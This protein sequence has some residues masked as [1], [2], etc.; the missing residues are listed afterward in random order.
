M[1]PDFK[2]WI[3]EAKA[4]GLPEVIMKHGGLGLKRQGHRLTGPCPKCGGD[5]RFYVNPDKNLFNCNGCDCGKGK[6]GAVDFTEFL[7]GCD[8]LRAC[9]T[10]TGRP[11]PK[12][13]PNG[14]DKKG[15]ND[16]PV[17]V[18][19]YD[20][21]DEGGELHY[22]V[23]RVQYA[24]PDGNWILKGD[25]PKKVFW[26]RRPDSRPG[27]WI[28]NVEGCRV[29]PYRL[30][31]LLEALKTGHIIFHVEGER[32]VNLLHDIGLDA[33][34]NSGGSEKWT[35]EHSAFFPAGS[36]NI[37]L[38]DADAAGRK[39][40]NVVAASLKEVGAEVK[41]LELPGLPGKGDIVDWV[42]VGGT[43]EQLIELARDAK[44]WIFKNGHDREEL[45]APAFVLGA[46]GQILKGHPFNISL[47]IERLG[48]VL[49]RNE[50][51]IQIEITNLEGYGPELTDAG[52]I[53][54]RL[55]THETF[56]FLPSR[57]LFEQI[58]TD[59]AHR[60]RYHP[61][62]DFLAGLKW[63]GEPRIDNWLK[64]YAGAEDTDFNRAVGRIILIAGVRRVRQP[65]VKFDT[66][67]V[68]ESPQGRDKS[69]ALR[70]LATKGEWF[71][72]NLP[73]SADP[74]QVIEATGGVWIAEFAELDGITK[75]D[76]GHVKNF[77]SKQDDR[78]RAAYGRRSERVPRQ[79]ICCGTTNDAQYLFD[80][81][82][83]RF[84]PV[85]ITQFNF[86]ALKRVIDQLWAE[87]AHYEAE[88]ESIVLQ[89][90]LWEA[91]R[92]VQ[93]ARETDNPIRDL[94]A[95]RLGGAPGWVSSET[96]WS[97]I[98]NIPIDRRQ[99]LSAPVGRAMKSLGFKRVQ[100]RSDDE[101]RGLKKDER[102]Y[103]RGQNEKEEKT[104]IW[105][106]PQKTTE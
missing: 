74:K 26:Q 4:T 27:L 76:V 77:L 2:A 93:G 45:P 52:A 42:E 13:Q 24:G 71:T 58:L 14:H 43:R 70:A 60:N 1:S 44:P 65:G 8:F 61:V 48:V 9:E 32:K 55:A 16:R 104:Q 64:D 100:C 73:L 7:D 41:V 47:A 40:L 75:R 91:A 97:I 51:S 19:A 102:Y 59:I 39:H 101:A 86:E 88:G 106:W 84:W 46:E 3:E 62:R 81:E 69:K 10:L 89:E 15:G 72:D 30:P 35:D 25:K 23:N 85:A 33:T 31:E 99:T 5:D 57:D 49:R 105:L 53:R 6:K 90:D 56:G 92:A 28:G 67:I 94:L 68:F 37:I 11:P 63:D 66:M 36:I 80:D 18:E 83:R 22:Q 12:D 54:L 38:P 29:L 82:N 95:S 96:I 20:Y 87:A 103:V 50:F 34:C 21:C 98:F 78:A 17:V 79:F